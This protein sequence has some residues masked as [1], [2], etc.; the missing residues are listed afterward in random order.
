ML[1]SFR[2]GLRFHRL[3]VDVHFREF[4]VQTSTT[5]R[6]FLEF[7][8]ESPFLG[9]LVVTSRVS[10]GLV[11]DKVLRYPENQV[12][13][14][15]VDCLKTGKKR[16]GDVLADPALV[17]LGLPIQLERTH[18]PKLGQSCPEDTQIDVVS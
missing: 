6:E 1:D 10:G 17:L 13:P 14:E 2:L 5:L 12:E 3:P 11:E 8:V 4:E 16:E 18:G 9:I 7:L 15:Q